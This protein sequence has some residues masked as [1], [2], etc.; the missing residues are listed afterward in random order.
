MP[1]IDAIPAE[2]AAVANRH[3]RTPDR[4]INFVLPFRSRCCPRKG[5]SGS[6]RTIEL[7]RSL[8]LKMIDVRWVGGPCA[9]MRSG[10]VVPL[11]NRDHRCVTG[12]ARGIDEV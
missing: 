3:R 12:V 10:P 1:T 4:C 9:D 11:P 5:G 7:D 2:V 8:P 6:Q